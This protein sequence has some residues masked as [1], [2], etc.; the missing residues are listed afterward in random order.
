MR[1]MLITFAIL[2]LTISIA[3]GA[4]HHSSEHLTDDIDSRRGMV[5]FENLGNDE[6]KLCNYTDQEIWVIIG[7]DVYGLW[8]DHCMY[9]SLIPGGSDIIIDWLD[10]TFT[11]IHFDWRGNVTIT[12]TRDKSQRGAASWD[13]EVTVG[14]LPPGASI[15]LPG[16]GLDGFALFN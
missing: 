13:G 12:N 16:T 15:T 14:S 4:A 6:W 2:L 8:P 11:T 9:F 10:G 5:T 1:R 7:D 3:F